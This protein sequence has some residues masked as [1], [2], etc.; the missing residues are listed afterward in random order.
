MMNI[1]I[2]G[3]GLIGGSFGLAIKK[4]IP[5][6]IR[7]IDTNPEHTTLALQLGL[8]DEIVSL[9]EGISDADLI[10]IAIPV[11]ATKELML[12]ILDE[13]D[14]HTIVI[15]AGS[16]K[17]DLCASVSMHPRRKNYVAAH[18]IAGTENNG[19]TAAFAELFENKMMLICEPEETDSEILKKAEHIFSLLN[20]HIQYVT[21]EEHDRQLAYVS[22]LSHISSFTLGLTVLGME[23]D[24]SSIFNLAGSGFA[25]TVR[26]AKSS[27]EMWSPI[28]VQNSKHI[29][30]ALNCYIN[31]LERFRNLIEQR[32]E[33]NL[34][35][36]M[37]EA[38][39]I[40]KVLDGKHR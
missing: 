33:Q 6:N 24:D 37:F 4:L 39:Q 19:P 32:R 30:N 7:G 23:K 21:P 10:Y 15:D 9:D 34:K 28:F 26:L 14:E 20:M 17:S 13:I 3:L 27:P 18:P 12:K 8:V 16:T 38:N 25:S 35:E 31:E 22:H 29:I 36:L 5:C 2:I 1:S 11:S 40:R